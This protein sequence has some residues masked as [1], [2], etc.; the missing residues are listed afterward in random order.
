MKMTNFTDPSYGRVHKGGTMRRISRK[1]IAVLV[2]ASACVII[3]AGCMLYH[4]AKAQTAET[5][6]MAQTVDK[7]EVKEVNNSRLKSRA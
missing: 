1:Q 5:L 4:W 3:I 6:A 2:A 7:A